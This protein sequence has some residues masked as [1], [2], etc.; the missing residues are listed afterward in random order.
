MGVEPTGDGVTRRPP[1]LKTGAVTG[2]HALPLLFLILLHRCMRV[3]AVPT[4]RLKSR[5]FLPNPDC[6]HVTESREF[7]RNCVPRYPVYY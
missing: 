7:D 6:G 4:A 2:L 3:A 5:K 1:V